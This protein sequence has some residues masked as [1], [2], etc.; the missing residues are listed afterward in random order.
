MEVDYL[1]AL[2]NDFRPKYKLTID[3]RACCVKM[4]NLTYLQEVNDVQKPNRSIIKQGLLRMRSTL[5]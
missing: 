3:Y 4:G 2:R 1:Q 5:I